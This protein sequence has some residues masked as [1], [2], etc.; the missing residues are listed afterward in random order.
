M[1][2]I[3]TEKAPAAIGP[4]S[5]AVS[6]NGL[7]FTSGQIALTAEGALLEGDVSAQTDQVFANLLAVLEAAACSPS[8]VIKCTVFLQDLG[9]F[10]V[11]NEIYAEWFGQHRPARAC[12]EVAGLPKGVA[13][14]IEA[15]AQIPS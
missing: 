15:I 9:D 6:A 11:V 4:Y 14:E 10:A 1:K 12:V 3:S 7:L 5:Q 13:V 2:F 8:D